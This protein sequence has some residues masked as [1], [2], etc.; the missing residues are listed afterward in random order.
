MPFTKGNKWG[1]L[2]K[3]AKYQ[4]TLDKEQRRAFFDAEVEKD[5]KKTIKAARAEYKLDQYL[6]KAKETL[7][8]N[9]R[10]EIDFPNED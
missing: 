6:G 5:L 9:G 3:G 2:N 8:V 7:D 4:P 10:L 1:A